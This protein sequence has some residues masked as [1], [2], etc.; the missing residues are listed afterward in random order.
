[1]AGRKKKADLTRVALFVYNE[2]MAKLAILSENFGT[3]TAE[4][5]RRAIKHYIEFRKADLQMRPR[6]LSRWL[7]QNSSTI[8][9]WGPRLDVCYAQ[10][11]GPMHL[12]NT[13]F[14]RYALAA[15]WM[16][17]NC[18]NGISSYEVARDLKD[19]KERIGSC[20]AG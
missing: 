5:V 10:R 7:A 11:S 1:M 13:N 15:T 6:W 8:S 20:F 2:D 4:L 18:K 16:L 9:T 17:T 3:P 14:C 19:P 12:E